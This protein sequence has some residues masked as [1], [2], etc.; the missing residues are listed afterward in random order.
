MAVGPLG[1]GAAL[2]MGLK[3]RAPAWVYTKSKG[4]YA[5]VVLD[6]TLMIERS[7]E[8]ERF[9]GRKIKAADLIKGNVRRPAGGWG[10]GG[11]DRL[12]AAIEVAEGKR[13]G[14][15]YAHRALGSVSSVSSNAEAELA[16]PSPEWK[17]EAR[18]APPPLPPQIQNGQRGYVATTRSDRWHP[19]AHASSSSSRNQIEPAVGRARETGKERYIFEQD[20]NADSESRA[21]SPLL[22][23]DSL[24]DADASDPTSQASEAQEIYP[25]LGAQDGRDGLESKSSEAL[26]KSGSLRYEEVLPAYNDD[27]GGGVSATHRP[28]EKGLGLGV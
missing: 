17:Y 27:F 5:G 15:T 14:A 23:D 19:T 12:V 28:M 6:G 21:A 24:Y 26:E 25:R 11:V 7:D 20:A 3:D 9:Y 2:D 16:R 13:T 8:N 18:R 1:S 22:P 4:L 10:D